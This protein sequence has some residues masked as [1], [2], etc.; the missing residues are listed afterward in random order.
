M[1]FFLHIF[2]RFLKSIVRLSLW[3]FYRRRTVENPEGAKTN[4]PC[5]VIS[6]HPST[7]LD[8]LNTAVHIPRTLHFLANASLFKNPLASWFLN[9]FYCIPIERY[10]DTGGRPLDNAASF[11]KATAFLSGGGM[12]YIAPEGSSFVERRIR[13]LKTGTARIALNTEAANGFRLGLRILPVGL[14]YSDPARFRSTVLTVFGQP[15]RVA[16][17]Q[18]DWEA[19]PVIAV[20]KLTAHLRG[21]LAELTTDVTDAGEQLLLEKVESILDA[22]APLPPFRSFQRSQKVLAKLKSWRENEPGKLARLASL[23]SPERGGF[24]HPGKSAGKALLFLTSPL[25]LLGYAI[26]FPPCFLTKKWSGHLNADLHWM[27]TYIYSIGLL[28]YPIFLF[29]EIWLVGQLPGHWPTW[30][31][32]AAIFPLGM[33][34][35]WWLGNWRALRANAG[36]DGFAERKKEWEEV[37][38]M[39]G[40][41][42]NLT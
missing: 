3:V 21:R 1:K 42:S 34:A 22:H 12:L 16:G 10:Q 2:Y 28:V 25:F 6:N 40:L 20:Q 13:K 11:A 7:L 17:F 38:E 30:L 33:V 19:D 9:H 8:P 27:P 37:V 23:P 41:S 18:K 35:E 5:I 29:L 36:A 26:H 24:P 14:N 32:V 39:L 4:G 15:V 31:F